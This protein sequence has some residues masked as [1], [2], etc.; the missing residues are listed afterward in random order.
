MKLE[1][2]QVLC[3][4]YLTNTDRVGLQP[5]YEAIVETAGGSTSR[6]HR[7]QGLYGIFTW[8][9]DLARARVDPE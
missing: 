5:A 2:E 7:A 6:G 9:F 1:G 4:F 8:R 3:R